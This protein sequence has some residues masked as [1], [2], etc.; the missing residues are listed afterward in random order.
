VTAPQ[1]GDMA[2]W[3]NSGK[4]LLAIELAFAASA[5]FYSNG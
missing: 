1:P 2:T 3:V 4:D 5:E